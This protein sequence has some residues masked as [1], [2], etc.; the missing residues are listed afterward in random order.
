MS[1]AILPFEAIRSSLK[2]ISLYLSLS[3]IFLMNS[4]GTNIVNLTNHKS[5]DG[6][7]DWSPDGKQIVF[8]SN[9][10]GKLQLFVMQSDGSGIQKITTS[11]N[12]EIS[13]RPDWSSDG[14]HIV[15][16]KTAE[17]STSIHIMDVQSGTNITF[18]K[19]Q[20]QPLF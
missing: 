18:F 14:R 17:N 2:I 4:D 1:R 11:T 12:L 13:S 15:Y 19:F 5:F 9:R 8:T 16:N 3:E 20:P 7:P 10:H 6:Y